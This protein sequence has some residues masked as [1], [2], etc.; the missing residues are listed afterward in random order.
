[1]KVCVCTT[2]AAMAE[3]RA[4]R[5]AAALARIDRNLDVL[6]IDC[7]PRGTVWPAPPEFEGIRN[8]THE[9][10][11]YAYRRNGILRLVGD[12]MVSLTAQAAFLLTGIPSAE[13]MSTR[14]IGLTARLAAAR[15]DIYLGH[16]SDALIPVCEAAKLHG[17]PVVFDSME[18]HSD[19]EG[20]AK[21]ERALIR[22]AER[23]YLR[24]CSLVLT[25]SVPLA[26]ALRSTY[27]VNQLLAIYNAAPIERTLP[28]KTPHG[29]SLY[30][31]NA[32]VNSGLRVNDILRAMRS[33]PADIHLTLQGRL[34]LDGGATLRKLLADLG[35][36]ERVTIQPPFAPGDAVRS[37]ALHDVGL[38]LEP[39]AYRN[40]DLTVS[41]KMFDYLMAGLAVIA[42]DTAG[43]SEIIQRSGAG[44]TY[45]AGNADDLAARILDLYHDR[46]LLETMQAKAR[47]FALSEGNLEHELDKLTNSF[48]E[49]LTR[50]PVGSAAARP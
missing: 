23:K 32:V 12:K 2:Y 27:G 31:R 14:T 39:R 46:R 19:M 10:H 35:I 13:A 36:M 28:P 20:Q 18:F 47:S 40:S 41:N 26:N 5:Y 44:T 15:A 1:M 22:V 33:L 34:P 37:A 30:W 21:L 43:Q 24:G 11:Y 6:F 9:T 49:F 48:R 29:F 50:L 42:S 7:A 17:S 38:C 4:R 25:P 3:P 8:L 16:N 45:P